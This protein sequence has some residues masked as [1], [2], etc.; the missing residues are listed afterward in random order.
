MPEEISNSFINDNGRS[1]Q[2]MRTPKLL[3]KDLV[4][5]FLNPDEKR[6]RVR[7]EF[8]QE[9][10]NYY[11]PGSRILKV[12]ASTYIP[13]NEN[14]LPDRFVLAIKS[15]IEG[16]VQFKARYVI[17]GNTDTLNNMMVNY[18]VT[19]QPQSGRN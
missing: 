3:V 17:G 16:K 7:N 18:S 13:L 9:D 8:C 4:K 12:M 6:A 5:E 10:G 11:L 2:S 1:L 19:A 15:T 14:V